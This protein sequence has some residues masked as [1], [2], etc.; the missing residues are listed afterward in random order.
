MYQI[1]WK[2]ALIGL[3]EFLPTQAVLPSDRYEVLGLGKRQ[4]DKIPLL[5]Q[6]QAEE[7][8]NSKLTFHVSDD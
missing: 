8:A 3:I 2:K 6:K 4:I 5:V 7:P 1:L